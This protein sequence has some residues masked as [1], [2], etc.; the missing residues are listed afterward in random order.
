M[1]ASPF[2]TAIVQWLFLALSVLLIHRVG[3]AFGGRGSFE[4]ALLVV[5][6]LQLV[7]LAVQVV[8]LVALAL[9]PPLAGI[10][11]LASIVLFFWLMSGFIAELHGFASRQKVLVGMLLVIFGAGLAIAAALV[12]FFGPEAFLPDV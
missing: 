8:Q 9:A 6:W 12:A 10:I 5:V 2:R 3:R 11:G 7:M 4:D 1:M